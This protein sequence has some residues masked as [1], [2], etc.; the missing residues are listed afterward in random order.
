MAKNGNHK[1]AAPAVPAAP[2]LAPDV[3]QALKELGDVDIGTSSSAADNIVPLIYVLQ[4]LSPAV[5]RRNPAYVEGAEPGAFWLRGAARPIVPG[6]PGILVQPCYFEK[7]WTEWR[8]RE[9]GGGLVSVYEAG[10]DDR[11][12]PFPEAVNAADPNN[13]TRPK[14]RHNGNDLVLTRRHMVRVFTPDG[15]LPYVINFTSTGHITSRSWI[16][17][18]NTQLHHKAPAGIFRL[19]T[20]ERSNPMGTWFGV[21]VKLERGATLQELRDGLQLADAFTSG[22]KTAEV[23]SPGGSDK[24]DDEIPF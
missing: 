7:N 19:T 8:P 14:W 21:E 9:S 20:K 6:E 23:G 1:E 22:E 13:P 16:S 4:P 12:P 17:L 3:L 11:K 18:I 10:D 24:I 15:I 5:N 2:L